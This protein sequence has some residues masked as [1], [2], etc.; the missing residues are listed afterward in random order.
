[1]EGI[2][3]T[4]EYVKIL[5]ENLEQVS[6]CQSESLLSSNMNKT[7]IIPAEELCPEDQS[8]FTENLW[9]ELKTIKSGGP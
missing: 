2:T 8:E 4:E 9:G 1:M 3:T 7:Y 5:K 6:V